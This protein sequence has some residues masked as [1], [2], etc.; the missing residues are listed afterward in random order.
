MNAGVGTWDALVTHDD[1]PPT[2]DGLRLDVVHPVHIASELREPDIGPCIKRTLFLRVEPG[3]DRLPRVGRPDP[4]IEDHVV[5]GGGALPEVERALG[6]IGRRRH[7]QG[8]AGGLRRRSIWRPIRR[9]GDRNIVTGRRFSEML[10]Q[11]INAYQNRSLDS[12]QVM[13]ELV[14][15]ARH[16]Q[17]E[18]HR[19]ADLGLNDDQLAFYDAIAN[20]P[21]ALELGDETL[22]KIAAEL[23]IIVRRDATTD[24]NV[25]EQVRAKLRLAIKTLLRRY[26]YPPDRQEE[27]VKLVIQ[28]AEVI[29]GDAA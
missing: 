27:A 20:N 9:I 22:K 5:M 4:L 6:G 12:A 14:E 3:A 28:Q 8:P 2:I 29:A 10:Q 18:H 23:L 19:G 16:L 26:K 25:K 1:P 13:A 24:W 17:E 15:L 11:A 7:G 21:S